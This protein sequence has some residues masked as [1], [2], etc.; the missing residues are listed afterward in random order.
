MPSCCFPPC[1]E[2]LVSLYFAIIP[3]QCL[4]QLSRSH[5]SLQMLPAME[6]WGQ[7]PTPMADYTQT[8]D[9]I[10]SSSETPGVFWHFT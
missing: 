7:G 2:E 8:L 4:T 5:F 6:Y 3:E 10:Y 1:L 9:L